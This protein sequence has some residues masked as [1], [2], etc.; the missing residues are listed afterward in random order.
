MHEWHDTIYEIRTKNDQVSLYNTYMKTDTKRFKK[1]ISTF[2]KLESILIKL[3]DADVPYIIG[4]SVALYVQGNA[5]LPHDV[6]IMFTD[7]AHE[8]ANKVFGLKSEVVKRHNVSMVKSTPV[9]DGSVDFL[10]QY[11]A[12]ADGHIYRKPPLEKVD[13]AFKDRN[14]GLVPAEKIAIFKLIGRREH[15]NDLDDFKDLFQHPDFD[16]RLF[17][18]LVDL[19]EARN[20]V[21]NLLSSNDIN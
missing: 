3:E 13:V 20:L 5:R 18:E 17:W 21:S 15:H 11:A 6:D 14:I 12:I 10:S 4:G 2:P 19:F 8:S 9:D 16:K 1:V 7:N